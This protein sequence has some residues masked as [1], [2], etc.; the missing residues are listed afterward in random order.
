MAEE[1]GPLGLDSFTFSF[2]QG[3]SAQQDLE[4]RMN[5][6]QTRIDKIS[7]RVVVKDV[8]VV[9]Q[10]MSQLLTLDPSSEEVI[11]IGK[12]IAR[13]GELLPELK[14]LRR[15]HSVV[16]ASLEDPSW[17]VAAFGDFTG[18]FPNDL[19]EDIDI[20]TLIQGLD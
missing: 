10:F 14:S 11:L 7:N 12:A 5:A 2:E 1:E 9:D 15:R 13:I 8:R 4:L 3:K 16:T 17:L 20:D 6:I 19:P 18:N